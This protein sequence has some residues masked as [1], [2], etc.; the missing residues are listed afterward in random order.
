MTNLVQDKVRQAA[1]IL[2][3]QGIDAWMT[4]VRET[5]AGGDPVVPVVLERVVRAREHGG[6]QVAHAAQGCERLDETRQVV[7]VRERVAEEQ[8]A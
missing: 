4:L 8:H 5:P 7:G 1:D 2:R 3:E 6:A